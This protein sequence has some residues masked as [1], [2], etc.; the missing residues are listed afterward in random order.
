[1]CSK[2][3]KL[4]KQLKS[5]DVIGFDL[6]NTL[7]R[8]KLNYLYEFLFKTQ[9]K[10]LVKQRNYNHAL[11]ERFDSQKHFLF[12]GLVYDVCK[13]NLL[14]LNKYG[15]IDIATHGSRVMSKEEIMKYYADQKPVFHAEIMKSFHNTRDFHIFENA[16]DIPC[17]LLCAILIDDL[18]TRYNK[19]GD[20]VTIEAYRVVWRDVLE[21]LIYLFDMKFFE[22]DQNEYFPAIRR[23][24]DLFVEKIQPAVFDLLRSL[25]AEG[26]II[27][28]LTSSYVDYAEFLL[29]HIF[30]TGEW[31][32][33]FDLNLYFARKPTFFFT[34]RPFLSAENR[35][36][37]TEPVELTRGKFSHG[38][39]SQLDTFL[40]TITA[41]NVP[42]V[43]YFG[44]SVRSDVSPLGLYTSWKPWFVI[45]E[46]SEQSE[47]APDIEKRP[48]TA[49]CYWSSETRP[50]GSIFS[51]EDGS[52]SLWFSIVKKFSPH[53]SIQVMEDLCE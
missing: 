11:F 5:Y 31:N 34:E 45:E 33:I 46:L 38:C 49:Q 2:A 48:R 40:K 19:A 36:V 41:S 10:F 32:D 22:L 20:T 35:T 4:L 50:W 44:D 16:F 53:P 27:F 23:N 18:D 3:S 17:S 24:P 29:D 37:G 12:K 15:K 51:C 30:G 28:L 21:S 7:V 43:V 14:K 9:A 13:G 25:K 1:M 47:P 39:Y 6:D 42:K 52:D 8:Y 26:K